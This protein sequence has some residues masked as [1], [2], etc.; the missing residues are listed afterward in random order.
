MKKETIKEFGKLIYDLSKI[1]FAVAVITPLVNGDGIS[2]YVI[3]TIAFGII[4]GT[5][6]INRGVDND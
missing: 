3:F 6:F 4:A 2:F 5:I 1:G